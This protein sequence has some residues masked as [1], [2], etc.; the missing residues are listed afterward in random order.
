MH[1]TIRYFCDCD[2]KLLLSIDELTIILLLV[3]R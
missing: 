3:F 1:D 2:H